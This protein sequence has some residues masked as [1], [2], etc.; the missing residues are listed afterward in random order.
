M[1]EQTIVSSL[2]MPDELRAAGVDGIHD[3][4]LTADGSHL[5]IAVWQA[6]GRP[7][8]TLTLWRRLPPEK[9]REG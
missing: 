2:D 7:P 3:A 5:V 8:G 6:G 1:M 9:P 4:T